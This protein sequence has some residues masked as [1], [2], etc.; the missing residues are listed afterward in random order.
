MTYGSHTLS[1]AYILAALRACP[2]KGVFKR[3]EKVQ[4][5]VIS[6]SPVTR[7]YAE[8]TSLASVPSWLILGWQVE[9][10]L[11]TSLLKDMIPPIF[12]GMGKRGQKYVHFNPFT[13]IVGNNLQQPPPLSSEAIFAMMVLSLLLYQVDEFMESVVASQS[14]ERQKNDI[15]HSVDAIFTAVENKPISL[16]PLV[17]ENFGYHSMLN[18]TNGLTSFAT[19]ISRNQKFR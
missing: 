18:R 8:M 17:N 1:K 13:W 7:M 5:N 14:L 9:S 16:S 11:Y 4:A 15:R 10:E 2:V 12:P 19:T 3:L 6:Q